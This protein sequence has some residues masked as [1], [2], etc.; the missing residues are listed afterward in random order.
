MSKLL[1]AVNETIL[2]VWITARAVAEHYVRIISM[3]HDGRNLEA[4]TWPA[5]VA[6]TMPMLIA[7]GL[8]W[9]PTVGVG[10]FFAGPLSTAL[11]YL[12]VLRR[13]TAFIGMA[14]SATIDLAKFGMVLAYGKSAFETL[15]PYAFF[16]ELAYFGLLIFAVW[17]NENKQRYLTK[18]AAAAA[19]HRSSAN[20][21]SGH[22]R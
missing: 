3:Q 21:E 9:V 6:M 14:A 2:A 4:K 17:C 18:V 15:A 8:F 22:D 19:G 7:G 20:K 13:R 1:E 16:M 12:A 5:V 11:L 10:A